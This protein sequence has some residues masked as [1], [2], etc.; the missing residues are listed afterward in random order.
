MLCPK[1]GTEIADGV[2]RPDP[3]RRPNTGLWVCIIVLAALLV[4]ALAVVAI[5]VGAIVIPQQT[6]ASDEARLSNLR[7]NLQTMRSQLLLYKTQHNET[8]PT[9]FE[10]QLTFYTDISG[11]TAAR[12]DSAHTFGPYLQAVP[13]NPISGSK[14]VRVVEGARRDFEAPCEDAGW[15][16]NTTTGELRA[17]LPDCRIGPDGTRYNE[18]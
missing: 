11:G 12:P 5:M 10:R 18:L 4:L 13:I 2:P 3:P 1:C 9:D 6:R 17:D 14:A 8:Y 7:T 15:W 16:F